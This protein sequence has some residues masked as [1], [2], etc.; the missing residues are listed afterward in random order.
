ML[1]G[2][3][4]CKFCGEETRNRVYCDSICQHKDYSERFRGQR[5]PNYGKKYSKNA[6]E[7]RVCKCCGVLT[8]NKKYCH[9]SC[10]YKS[11]I[12]LKEKRK[13]LICGKETENEKYC[14]ME[15][16]HKSQKYLEEERRCL[17]CEKIFVIRSDIPQKYCNRKCM[18]KAYE[19]LRKGENNTMHGKCYP[20]GEKH[21]FF[22]KHHTD[23]TKNKI[24]KSESG[25]LVSEETKLKLRIKRQNQKFPYSNTKIEIKIQNYLKEK[26]IYFETQ[27]PIIGQPDIYIPSCNVLIFPDGDWWH[28][29]PRQYGSEDIIGTCKPAKYKWRYDK[30]ITT[31]LESQGYTVLRF[32]EWDI[33]HNFEDVKS[34]ILETISVI[35]SVL[36]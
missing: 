35:R 11:R 2:F 33:N 23:S 14:S 31:K 9:P 10:F 36:V 34:K 8:T 15:C 18:G 25:K 22:G 20:T 21:Y 26:E 1:K 24:S 12:I 32:W 5:G 6:K 4:F 29:N 27:Y 13:C 28:G 7:K 16:L 30:G 17:I 3:R 19:E